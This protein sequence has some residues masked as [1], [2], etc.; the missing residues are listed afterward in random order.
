MAIPQNYLKSNCLVVDDELSTRLTIKN[1]LK[2][3]GF[4]KIILTEN[5]KRALKFI[6]TVKIDLALVD[7]NMPVMS[8][9]ELFKTVR[10]DGRYDNIV[11]IFVT[12][13]S[14]R[15]A[16]AR[17]AEEGG[18]GYIVKPFI[19]AT[20]E[21]RILKTL[22]KKINPRPFRI[23]LKNFDFFLENKEFENAE[24]EL[25][26][27]SEIDPECPLITYRFG[28]MAIAMGDKDKAIDFYKKTLDL[29]PLFIRAYSALSEIYEYTGNIEW[30]ITYDE[31]AQ[32]ISP[33][34]TK[35]VIRLS[36]LY[37]SIGE[38][39][40]SKEILQNAI[41]AEKYVSNSV[42]LLGEMCMAQNENQKAVELLIKA[43]K[44]NHSDV[45]I[46]QSLAEAYLRVAKYGEAIEVYKELIKIKPK[47]A[48]AYYALGK[49]YLE[50]N[51]RGKGINCV[52]K[53]WELNP[54]SVEITTT[55]KS[56]AEKEK[57]EI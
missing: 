22:D 46:M 1:M 34:N 26:K 47:N 8:G 43:N 30:A 36:R 3:I 33:E 17:V 37:S 42:L 16:V 2:K 41:S 14:R 28:Q 52:K 9:I 18:D 32:Q 24:N 23:Y 45:S 7:V 31:L 13:E 54:F 35:R 51:A 55:L 15:P 20:L 12:A 40:K 49:V 29:N 4:E 53:A 48:F 19:M 5:G 25:K 27:A 6:K 44:E 39:E 21:D 56:L 38:A 10:E 50:M 11:F 57:I